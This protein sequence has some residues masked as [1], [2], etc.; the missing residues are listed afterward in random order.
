[1]IRG[2]PRFSIWPFSSPDFCKKIFRLIFFTCLLL[3]LA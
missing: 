2:T 3:I 1:M